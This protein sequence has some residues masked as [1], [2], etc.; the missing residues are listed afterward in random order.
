MNDDDDA[1]AIALDVEDN[2]VISDETGIPVNV[3]YI[4]GFFPIRMFNIVIPGLQRLARIRV[5]FPKLSQGS[6]DNDT[7]SELYH[8]APKLGTV[9]SCSRQLIRPAWFAVSVWVEQHPKRH[10]G[11]SLPP[12]A[13]PAPT[14]LENGVPAPNF[15]GY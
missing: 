9:V 4:C 2:P 12:E 15:A 3:F 7:H 11:V 6:A 5:F 8:A 14:L 13:E 1:I 10:R